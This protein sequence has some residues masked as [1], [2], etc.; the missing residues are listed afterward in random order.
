MY[1]YLKDRYC[2]SMNG[3]Y[4]ALYVKAVGLGEEFAAL[5]TF[6]TD[7]AQRTFYPL[8]EFGNFMDIWVT[9]FLSSRWILTVCQIMFRDHELY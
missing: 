5:S 9:W 8:L 2:K 4:S 3:P 7:F 1:I 6:D